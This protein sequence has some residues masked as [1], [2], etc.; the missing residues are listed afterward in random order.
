MKNKRCLTDSLVFHPD[1]IKI[2]LVNTVAEIIRANYLIII[3]WESW[4]MVEE[5]T[6]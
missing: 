4:K 6:L 2:L 1:F 5:Y 3:F